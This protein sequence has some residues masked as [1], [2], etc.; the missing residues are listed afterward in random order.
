MQFQFESPSAPSIN[1]SAPGGYEPYATEQMAYTNGFG[2]QYSGQ[3]GQLVGMGGMLEKMHNVA[4]RSEVPQVKRRRIG[5]L[6]LT[7]DG[8]QKKKAQFSGVKS[9]GLLGDY[10]KEKRK[11]GRHEAMDGNINGFPPVDL[12]EDDDQ[13]SHPISATRSGQGSVDL[14]ADEYLHEIEEVDPRDVE[15]CYGRLDGADVNTHRMPMPRPGQKSLNP[16]MWPAVKVI[17]KRTSGERS[18]LVRIVDHTRATIGCLDVTT[19][20][21]LVPVLDSNLGVRTS[22]RIL[23]RPRKPDDAPAGGDCSCRLPLDLVLYGPRKYAK[24]IGTHLKGKQLILKTP[25]IMEPVGIQLCNPHQ[26]LQNFVPRPGG[27]CTGYTSVS[28]ASMRTVEEVRSDVTSMF[29]NLKRADD[30]PETIPNDL[31]ITELL[32]HQKQGLTFMLSKEKSRV[33]GMSERENSSL[34]REKTL[35]SGRKVYAHVITSQQQNEPPEEVLGGILADMMGLGK[36][37]SILSLI[38]STRD[39]RMV[40]WA[41]AHPPPPAN[42]DELPIRAQSRATLLVSPLSTI[43][44]WEEQISQ[45]VRPGGLKYHI[46]HGNSKIKDIRELASYDLVITTYGSVSSEDS[47]RHASKPGPYPLAEINWFRIVLD[48]AHMI[49]EQ[50]TLQSKSIC[51]LQAQR[52]WAVTGTPV[53][54]RLDDLGAL[55]KFL[56]LKPFDETRAFRQYIIGPCKSADAEIL[57]KIRLLV[58]SIT[59]RRLKDRIDLPPRHDKIIKLEFSTEEQQLYDTFAKHATNTVKVLTTQQEKVLGGRTYAHILQSILRLRLICAHGRELLTEEDLKLTAG[60]TKDQAIDLSDEEDDTQRP[61][62]T[63]KQAYDMYTL[64][65]ETNADKCGQCLNQIGRSTP[66]SENEG[67]DEVLGY[68]TPCLHIICTQHIN[69]YKKSCEDAS[70]DRGKH[71]ACPLCNHYVRIDYFPLKASEADKQEDRLAALKDRKSAKSMG[72]Y[73]GPHTKTK[74]LIRELL[75]SRAESESNPNEPPI[76][77]VVFSGWTSHLDLIQMALEDNHI[78]FTR[79]DGKMSR[80]A[81]GVALDTFRDDAS[82]HVI[83]V[84]IAAGGLGLNLTTANKVYVMEPQ[85]NPAAE[86][87]A[88]DRVHR[89][90]QKRNVETFRFVMA[91]SFEEK[92]LELQ[93]KK[94]KLASLS[95]DRERGGGRAMRGMG[96]EEATRKRLEDLRSLFK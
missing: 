23:A 34:W 70:R 5:S 50:S 38:V 90:G 64:M 79:L 51:K 78:T 72:T 18:N 96:R 10:M 36:T 77:S 74:E 75:A 19:A 41:N 24:Q 86:A 80:P 7:E 67:K 85:Y 59:L 21:G 14:T 45:H 61:A 37:L 2:P 89:L 63:V 57:P 95:M 62:L 4:D 87:Q 84:S 39:Q 1:G 60:I 26:E 92:M 66:D 91:N 8:R 32:K 11:E 55:L 56:R 47:R 93:E 54:N 88:I 71:A 65:R 17:L 9:G 16:Q 83:L 73:S 29:D 46:Y 28:S 69:A 35:S 31:I 27:R 94:R 6:D 44:N 52:R 68:M 42:D 33:Y 15:V 3:N 82:V 25:F 20:I 81:R 22:A 76:K 12:T 40:E 13:K 58:D 43:A 53:Q 30:L 48:E 49:R